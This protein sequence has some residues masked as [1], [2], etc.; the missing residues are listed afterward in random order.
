MEIT[1]STVIAYLLL[2]GGT[3]D[4][5]T[6]SEELAERDAKESEEMF[7]VFNIKVS[8]NCDKEAENNEDVRK[9]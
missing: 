2:K 5:L 8:N 4:V 3:V 7:H 9:M 1:I 6:S